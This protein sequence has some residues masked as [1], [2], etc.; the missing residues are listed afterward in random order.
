MRSGGFF[1]PP[2]PRFIR[3]SVAALVE[4][5]IFMGWPTQRDRGY[6]EV[7]RHLELLGVAETHSASLD[8]YAALNQLR[9]LGWQDGNEIWRRYVASR[10]PE[11]VTNSAPRQVRLA[12]SRTM[13]ARN[14]RGVSRLRLPIPLAHPAQ[15]NIQWTLDSVGGEIVEQRISQGAIDL[16][17]RTE[18][19]FVHARIVYSGH[20]TPQ[21]EALTEEPPTRPLL[22]TTSP[23]QCPEVIS[24][25]ALRQITARSEFERMRELWSLFHNHLLS[26][27][28][29]H[30]EH[31]ASTTA[32]PLEHSCWFDCVA[33]TWLYASAAQALGLPARVISGL[34]LHSFGPAPHYWCEVFLEGGWRPFDLY[35]WDLA[36]GE[37]EW[38]DVFFGRLDCRLRF[39]CLPDVHSRF[40]PNRPMFIERAVTAVG[41][42]F[43]YRDVDSGDVLARDEWSSV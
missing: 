27:H 33:G 8:L 6:E 32:L 2:K 40:L 11:V 15:T 41:T 22:T 28:I 4:E 13:P 16:N 31:L 12:L 18:D 17:L 36:D 10:R 14:G 25:D 38:R 34:I 24:S 35:A 7:P 26:G 37:S 1:T 29:Y 30:H 3:S 42:S 43:T 20:L 39:E 21:V 23:F 5:G 9:C 19:P